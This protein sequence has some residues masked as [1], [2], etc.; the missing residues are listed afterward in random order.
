MTE[1]RKIPNHEYAVELRFTGENLVPSDVSARLGL[2]PTNYYVRGM[3]YPN[4]KN[5]LPFW[6][7]DAQSDRDNYR[8]WQ[9]LEEG[10]EFVC[11][12]LRSKKAE[13]ITLSREFKGL[14]WCGHFQSSF[15]G[16]PTL[17]PS[18]LAEIASYGLP[19]FIDN[20]FVS[21]TPGCNLP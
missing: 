3:D 12:E 11:R 17:S 18:F 20:H 9:S 10:F 2:L 7:Y 8:G 19:I 4:T 15:D 21:D 13:I 1:P 16:G 6:G 14:W 5:R